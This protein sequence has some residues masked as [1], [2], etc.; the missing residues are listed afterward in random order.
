[1]TVFLEAVRT[2]GLGHLSYV[3]GDDGQAAVIDPRRDCNLYIAIASRYGAQVMHVFETHCHE[4]LVIGSLELAR[5]TKAR[6]HHGG[7]LLFKYGE[8]VRD[9]DL[10]ELGKLILKILET[11]GHTP[12]SIA[13]VMIDKNY[14][15]TA[16]AVF[17]GDTLLAGDT[18]RIDLHPSASGESAE[19]LYDSLHKK[20][21]PL[22][23]QAIIYPAHGAGYIS[24]MNPIERDFST[25]GYERAHNPALKKNRKTFIKDKLA[26][27]CYYAPYFQQ[28]GRFNQGGIRLVTKLPGPVPV[29]AETFSALMGNE[30]MFVLDIRGPESFAGAHIPGSLNIPLAILPAYAGWFLP[31]DKKIGLIAE[32]DS[33]IETARLFLMRLGYDNAAWYLNGGIRTWVIAGKT[34]ESIPTLDA[35]TLCRRVNEAEDTLVLDVRNNK[36][37]KETPSVHSKRI[38]I[39]E[40]PQKTTHLPQDKKIV[41]LCDSG[42]RAS[43]AAS[44][45]KQK[46]DLFKS[47]EICLGSAAAYAGLFP[48]RENL[49]QQTM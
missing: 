29:N 6:I 28:I 8:A 24:C 31:Y 23:D 37:Y 5:R 42:E 15:D 40:L 1:M 19:K 25:I 26:E 48:S 13:I 38:W 36:E 4:D 11:P 49:L 14:G 17:T 32:H 43:L 47:V 3:L 12:E 16:L 46:K 9:G 2:D 30:K 20:I 35:A 7:A 22:G 45:L 10:F 18:G 34:L 39:G 21:L 27:E 44:L 41:T 33:D